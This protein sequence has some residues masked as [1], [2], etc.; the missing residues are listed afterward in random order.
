VITPNSTE[1]GAASCELGVADAERSPAHYTVSVDMPPF[2]NWIHVAHRSSLQSYKK[3]CP[4][5]HLFLAPGSVSPGHALSHA[6]VQNSLAASAPYPFNRSKSLANN[7]RSV[8]TIQDAAKPETRHLR[9]N[10]A[11]GLSSSI[12]LAADWCDCFGAEKSAAEQLKSGHWNYLR[13]AR[14]QRCAFPK[15]L[16]VN[17][18]A[19]P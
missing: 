14:T 9:V 2:R 12:R 17:R 11:R 6:N 10:D 13:G 18:F 1:L 3:L 8:A 5:G 16:T 19:H 4:L 7:N 15:G